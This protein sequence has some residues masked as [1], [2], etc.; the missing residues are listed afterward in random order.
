MFGGLLGALSYPLLTFL[1]GPQMA[2]DFSRAVDIAAFA[3]ILVGIFL[4]LGAYIRQTATELAVTNRRLIA[5]YGFISRST[6]EILTSRITGANFDQTITG[7]LLGYGT[8][9]VHGAG[10]EISPFDNIDQPNLFYKALVTAQGQ[11]RV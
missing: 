4:L 1:F 9:F 2:H 3:V 11:A 7:R 6:Y 10:G 5:K 8:I